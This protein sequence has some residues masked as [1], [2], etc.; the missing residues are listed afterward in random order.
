MSQHTPHLHKGF[1]VRFDELT[2]PMTLT[3]RK[4][5]WDALEQLETG[6]E[7]IVAQRYQVKSKPKFADGEHKLETHY[8]SKH[9]AEARAKTLRDAGYSTEI[10]EPTEPLPAKPLVNDPPIDG[11]T[12]DQRAQQE[13][14]TVQSQYIRNNPSLPE[15]PVIENQPPETPEHEWLRKEKEAKQHTEG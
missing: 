15:N 2:E 11:L 4:A 9:E 12:D 7:E 14:A 13:Q 6:A 5:T 1:N 3:M 8:A 10:V